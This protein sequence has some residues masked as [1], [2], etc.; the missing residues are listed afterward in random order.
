M[1]CQKYLEEK[2]RKY[3]VSFTPYDKLSQKKKKAVAHL[4][5]LAQLLWGKEDA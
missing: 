3:I 2:V 1:L 5:F 4:G